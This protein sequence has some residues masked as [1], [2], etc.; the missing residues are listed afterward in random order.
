MYSETDKKHTLLHY[1]ERIYK[2]DLWGHM[3]NESNLACINISLFQRRLHWFLGALLEF[4]GMWP[5]FIGSFRNCLNFHLLQHFKYTSSRP[6]V[7]QGR[8]TWLVWHL[9]VHLPLSCCIH[10]QFYVLYCLC[11]W[12]SKYTWLYLVSHKSQATSV[13]L[14]FKALAE[15]QTD[16]SLK[17]LQNDNAKGI[18]ISN[19]SF[20]H[21]W[22]LS[23][24]H[25]SSH[26]Q[27]EWFGWTQTSPHRWH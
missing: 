9:L 21:I 26:T 4:D 27:T 17:T 6:F 14:Q 23:Q 3:S 22:Y 7:H 15:N 24:T 13:F 2:I 18:F 1:R 5:W 11:W 20:E 8:V 25:L 10:Q 12:F 19:Q 16:Y